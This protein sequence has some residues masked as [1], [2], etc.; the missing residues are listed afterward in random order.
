MDERKRGGYIIALRATGDSVVFY[1]EASNLCRVSLL[2]Q[3]YHGR[4]N[5]IRSLFVFRVFL[6]KTWERWFYCLLAVYTR[7]Q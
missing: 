5:R 3:P 2:L 1:I 6:V 7:F 4:H